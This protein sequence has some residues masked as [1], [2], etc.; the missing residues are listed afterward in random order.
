MLPERRLALPSRC[1]PAKL[2][3]FSGNYRRAGRRFDIWRPA[4]R[5][6][7]GTRAQKRAW[8]PKPGPES[9]TA[10]TRACL[11]GIAPR[12]GSRGCCYGCPVR[13]CYGSIRARSADYC[14][15]SRREAFRPCSHF[16]SVAKNSLA[17]RFSAPPFP[18]PHSVWKKGKGK[19]I[20]RSYSHTHRKPTTLPL[21]PGPYA[22]RSDARAARA[23]VPRTAAKRSQRASRRSLR[24]LPLGR[25][26]VCL[27]VPI[28]GP[29][30]HVA[31]H[32]EQ[33]KCVRLLLAYRV[34]LAS[35]VARI[36]GDIVQVAI[37]RTRGPGPR[38]I[39]PFRLSGQ[40]PANLLAVAVSLIPGGAQNGRLAALNGGRL[41]REPSDH[42]HRRRRRCDTHGSAGRGGS[43]RTGGRQPIRSRF[44]W[45]HAAAA[46]VPRR[47]DTLVD[48]NAGSIA[49]HALIQSGRLTALDTSRLRR[50]LCDH[51]RS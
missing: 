31:E 29:L 18:Q 9:R 5:R 25:L 3:S 45:D 42:R 12:T 22:L 40:A 13:S 15:T 35:T 48:G 50:E 11:A 17:W 30:P 23:A 1:P 24:I 28:P 10:L 46:G 14:S 39:L 27:R 34:R 37:A 20:K 21:R 38:R 26:I 4:L 7:A 36:P 19:R 47:A 33:S 49:I 51:R 8:R 41:R 44:A 2:R 6:F 16:V 32:I 43:A